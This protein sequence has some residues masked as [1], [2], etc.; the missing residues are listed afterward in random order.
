MQVMT[1]KKPMSKQTLRAIVTLAIVGLV[2]APRPAHAQVFKVGSFVKTTV[3]GNQANIPHNL[4]VIPK[5]M[6]FWM[7]GPA[8]SGTS[9][10]HQFFSLGFT[11][12][13]TNATTTSK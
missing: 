1:D 2:C 13:T 11:D 9:T 5:A 3:T 6:I 12:G 4:G 8:T 10:V 7:S